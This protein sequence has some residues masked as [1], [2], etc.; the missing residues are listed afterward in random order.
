MPTVGQA[1]TVPRMTG[2]RFGIPTEAGEAPP[3]VGVIHS[4]SQTGLTTSYRLRA[5][6]QVSAFPFAPVAFR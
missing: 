6:L 1:A 2:A 4:Q 5:P 3:V